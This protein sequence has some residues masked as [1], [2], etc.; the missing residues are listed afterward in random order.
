M[1]EEEET[2]GRREE[3]DGGGEGARRNGKLRAVIR[4]NSGNGLLERERV[5]ASVGGENPAGGQH[6]QLIQAVA[7]LPT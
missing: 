3:E 4:P 6:L 5:A 7:G 1:E 2:G